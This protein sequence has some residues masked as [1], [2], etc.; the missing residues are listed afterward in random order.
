MQI[1]GGGWKLINRE[2]INKETRLNK[3]MKQKKNNFIL[4]YIEALLH[5]IC[6]VHYQ[7]LRILLGGGGGYP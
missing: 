4:I 2:K 5:L 1:K 6:L 7:S 3:R